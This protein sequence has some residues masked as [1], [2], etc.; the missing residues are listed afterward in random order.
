MVQIMTISARNS[1]NIDLR[2]NLGAPLEF[3]PFED[4]RITIADKAFLIQWDSV[5][6]SEYGEIHSYRIENVDRDY[7]RPL[8]R[9]VN[10]HFE[11]I[12]FSVHEREVNFSAR[13]PRSNKVAIPPTLAVLDIQGGLINNE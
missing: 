4:I 8:Y 13:E 12:H 11:C 7:I 5:W 10:D 6:I 9:F 3:N 2:G 1:S